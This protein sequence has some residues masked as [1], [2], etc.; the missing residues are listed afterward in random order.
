MIQRRCNSVSLLPACLSVLLLLFL[1]SGYKANAQNVTFN[2]VFSYGSPIDDQATGIELDANG[3]FYVT[4]FFSGTIDL[5]PGPGTYTFTTNTGGP[6]NYLAKFKSDGSLDWAWRQTCY[7]TD[8][9]IRDIEVDANGDVI[10]TGSFR[11]TVDFDP[12]PGTFNLT[13]N[14]GSGG[15][16]DIFIAK[17]S[18]GGN[19]IY[20]IGLGGY[21]DDA[22]NN[23]TLDNSGDIIITGYFQ[24][25]VDFDPSTASSNTLLSDGGGDVFFMKLDANGTFIW[26]KQLGGPGNDF[27]G[28]VSTGKENQILIGGTF[29][30]SIDLDPGSPNYNINSAGQGDVFCGMY[31]SNGDWIWGFGLEGSDADQGYQGLI[32]MDGNVFLTGGTFGEVDLD[33]GPGVYS[34]LLT[35]GFGSFLG[36]YGAG[37]EFVF[38]FYF[39]EQEFTASRSLRTDQFGQLYVLGVFTNTIDLDPG[40]GVAQLTAI[41]EDMFLAKYDLK[42]NLRW[43]HSIRGQG[44]DNGS[45][46]DISPRGEI[47][48]V[49]YT[50]ELTDF[51]IGTGTDTVP[52]NG[53]RQAFVARYDQCISVYP[54]SQSICPNESY[55][56]G[57]Q[58]LTAAGSYVETVSLPGGCDSIVT[59]NLSVTPVDTGVSLQGFDLVST[60]VG[61]TYEWID[62]NANQVIAGATLGTFTPT[63]PGDY[64]V[65]VT[66]NGC[67]DTS[68]C[69]TITTVDRLDAVEDGLV[70]IYP[71]PVNVILHLEF[72]SPVKL[73][74]IRIFDLTG[75]MIKSFAGPGLQSAFS[76]VMPD[77][78]PGV[79]LLA[80]DFADG[81]TRMIR[82]LVE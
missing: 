42:G 31:Q 45:G 21:L 18:S 59:L 5:D 43:A 29:Q 69:L 63:A 39:S 57:G 12:G 35:T 52:W 62:C 37:G 72:P 32:D 7:S 47:I 34:P 82:V 1:C 20:A 13:A 67:S 48:I 24:D 51:N 36:K 78:T 65:I 68:A 25:S 15:G 11:Q 58:T 64:A 19:L 50:D 49:G 75:R 44:S 9:K 46:I 60:A 14:G 66:E 54:D 28:F 6:D 26:V 56:L 16:T 73:R 61:A 10:I 3:D 17:Y 76:I 81:R 70:R 30:Q 74:A 27:P 40:Q 33:P 80:V 79:Y 8:D 22:S 4:G 2:D 23:V 55:V 53:Y 77:V 38:G 71:N 41:Q